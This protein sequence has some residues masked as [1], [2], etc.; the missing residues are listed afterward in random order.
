L[1][2]LI[3]GAQRRC[4]TLGLGPHGAKRIAPSGPR[5]MRPRR[6]PAWVD[7]GAMTLGHKANDG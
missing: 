7:G 1:H 2:D 6:A 5:V 4:A 3:F